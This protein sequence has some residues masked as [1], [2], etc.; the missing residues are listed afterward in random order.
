MPTPRA[1]KDVLAGL[2][3]IGFG[4]A[5]G[6]AAARYPLGTA[7]RMGPGYFPLLL[8]GALALL[9]AAIVGKGLLAAGD[10]ALGPVPWRAAALVTAALGFFGATVAG[11][12]LGPALFVTAFVSALAS[13][14]NGLLAAALLAAGLTAL[15][16]LIFSYGLG[17]PVP[18]IG[19]WL[20]S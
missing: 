17:V 8:A 10:G 1:S 11:L 13:R 4:L 6:I 7:L 18:V 3:F 20:R 15:C 12:G 16:L 5:F 2:I 19:P 9:G 14:A